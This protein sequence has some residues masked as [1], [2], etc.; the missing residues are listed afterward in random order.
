M[1]AFEIVLLSPRRC[2]NMG[3]VVEELGGLGERSQLHQLSPLSLKICFSDELIRSSPVLLTSKQFQNDQKG[4]T[5]LR[6][7]VRRHL[8]L[9]FPG[10]SIFF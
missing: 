9:I 4:F 3:L 5:S 2:M 6:D 1:N 8:T 10:I 7:C